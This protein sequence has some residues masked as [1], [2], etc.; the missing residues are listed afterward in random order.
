MTAMTNRTRAEPVGL[1]FQ[2]GPSSRRYLSASATFGA[3]MR[4]LALEIRNRSWDAEQPSRTARS[5]TQLLDAEPE[6][7]ARFGGREDEFIERGVQIPP[8]ADGQPQLQSCV[9]ILP[10]LKITRNASLVS[11]ESSRWAST[12]TGARVSGMPR[13]LCFRR[14]TRFRLNSQPPGG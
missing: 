8:T 12:P 6:Q 13:C 14:A 9:A 3:S 10:F 5:E 7:R 4:L 11:A 2:L 1:A